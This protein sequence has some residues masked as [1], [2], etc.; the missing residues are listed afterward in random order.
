[1]ET[2]IKKIISE[3]LVHLG[4]DFTD[5][6]VEKV[7]DRDFRVNITSEDPSLLIG[8][9]GENLKAMQKVLK[10]MIFRQVGDDVEIKLD[11]DNYRKRQEENVLTI[12]AQKAD[13]VRQTGVKVAL[14]P[15]SAYFRRLVHL[16]ILED[17]SDLITESMGEGDFR[18]V[19]IKTKA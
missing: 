3:F 4:L 9:H 10:V 18:Q 2:R 14:P 17:H 8:Y 1:M 6:E 7:A 15:M 11:V 16:M 19:V 5:V 12:A 13:E